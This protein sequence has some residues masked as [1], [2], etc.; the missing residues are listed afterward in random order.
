MSAVNAYVDISSKFSVIK[1][2]HLWC[3]LIMAWRSAFL[4]MHLMFSTCN[5]HLEWWLVFP[6]KIHNAS[7]GKGAQQQEKKKNSPTTNNRGFRCKATS[8]KAAES[9][10]SNRASYIKYGSGILVSIFLGSLFY[11]AIGHVWCT[12]HIIIL[13]D[14]NEGAVWSF[15]DL[16]NQC[17]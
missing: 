4:R 6:W 9:K 15:L 17:I 14:R 2:Q 3:Q 1:I 8:F 5:L 16:R 11:L 7:G 12:L 13:V 10:E